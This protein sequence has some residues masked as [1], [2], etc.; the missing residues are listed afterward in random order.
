MSIWNIEYNNFEEEEKENVKNL[1]KN[2]IN[3]HK[4]ILI[5][6]IVPSSKSIFSKNG[7]GSLT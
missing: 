7:V 4:F 1:N 6:K 5:T 2:D 3:T